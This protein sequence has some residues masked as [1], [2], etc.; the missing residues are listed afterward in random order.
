MA[1][2]VLPGFLMEELGMEHRIGTV[3]SILDYLWAPT[4]IMYCHGLLNKL[5]R[6]TSR[7]KNELKLSWSQS[8]VN[9]NCLSISVHIDDCF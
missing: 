4:A 7:D 9:L 5:K 3:C 2:S 8:I 1:L 6:L